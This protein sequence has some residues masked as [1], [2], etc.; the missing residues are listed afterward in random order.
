MCFVEEQGNRR[1]L[2]KAAMKHKWR[3]SELMF[4]SKAVCYIPSIGGYE[5]NCQLSMDRQ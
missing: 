1:Q 2:A 4:P 3:M 5:L